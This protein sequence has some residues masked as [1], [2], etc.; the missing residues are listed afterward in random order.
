MNPQDLVA[1]LPA[2]YRDPK[3]DAYEGALSVLSSDDP[4]VINQ[5]IENLLLIKDTLDQALTR[6]IDK[7]HSQMSEYLTGLRDA[8][9]GIQ[10]VTTEVGEM[11]RDVRECRDVLTQ[12]RNNLHEIW[13]RC[14]FY[15]AAV[16]KLEQVET[17]ASYTRM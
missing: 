9:E 12:K 4:G 1:A 5:T 10:E 6:S 16:K 2:A 7:K 14:V 15:K 3:F 13:Y 11:R 8:E 17:A